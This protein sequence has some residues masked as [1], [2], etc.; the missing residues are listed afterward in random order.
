MQLPPKKVMQKQ[1]INGEECVVEVEV[2]VERKCLFKFAP[3]QV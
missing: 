2:A 1:I 3:S